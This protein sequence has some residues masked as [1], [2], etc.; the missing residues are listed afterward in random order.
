MKEYES[1]LGDLIGWY[2]GGQLSGRE[3]IV[4]GFE[5]AGRAF[6][7]MMKGKNIGKMIIKC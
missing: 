5:N 1:C 2:M 6:C 7:E 3:T 4:N